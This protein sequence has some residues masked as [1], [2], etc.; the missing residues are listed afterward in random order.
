MGASHS[1]PPPLVSVSVPNGEVL[2][3]SGSPLTIDPY[4]HLHRHPQY[5]QQN[6]NLLRNANKPTRLRTSPHIPIY[7]PCSPPS[8]HPRY[9]AQRHQEYEVL[10]GSEETESTADKMMGAGDPRMGMGRMG[11]RKGGM[12]G[13]R[14]RFGGGRAG[15]FEDERPRSAPEVGI[16]GRMGLGVG[17]G[18]QDPKMVG[19]GDITPDFGGGAA[20]MDMGMGM[21]MS[22]GLGMMKPPTMQPPEYTSNPQLPHFNNTGLNAPNRLPP[23]LN[24]YTSSPARTPT[25][26]SSN[27]SPRTNQPIPNRPSK[28]RSKDYTSVPMGAYTKSQTPHKPHRSYTSPNYAAQVSRQGQRKVGASGRDWVDGNA[29]LDA[30]TCTTNCKC[31]KSHRVIYRRERQRREGSNDD[32]GEDSDARQEIGE[33]R[34]ILRDDLG[35]DCDDHSGCRKSGSRSVSGTESESRSSEKGSKSKKK[36]KKK[37]RK[38]EEKN[39]KERKDQFKNMKEE[40]LE[41]LDDRIQGIRD[42]GLQQQQSRQKIPIPTGT[43]PHPPFGM[44]PAMGSMP[45]TREEMTMDPRI[46]QHIAMMQANPQSM[47]IP[48]IMH[49]MS[50]SMPNHPNTPWDPAMYPRDSNDPPFRTPS[51]TPHG[52]RPRRPSFPRPSQKAEQA[53]PRGF[54]RNRITGHEAARRTAR[55]VQTQH[56]Q[57]HDPTSSD[58]FDFDVND[59]SPAR[60]RVMAGVRYNNGIDG[61]RG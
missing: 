21:G 47:N 41:A 32:D 53:G 7:T 19:M 58:D 15:Y 8:R 20:E 12:G 54:A 16:G 24:P 59:E 55:A 49:Q 9:A 40:L 42:V 43:M 10:E 30:C 46:A 29:F 1:T 48:N 25:T 38:E 31:R 27:S 51:T 50:P 34:Y 39:A 13:L 37:K 23:G 57:H 6:K 3:P 18:G 2:V 52:A 14:G 44:P 22:G 11:T 4:G 17:V 60:R 56:H 61:L 5:L 35:K 45:F 28:S 26:F 33:I 36:K